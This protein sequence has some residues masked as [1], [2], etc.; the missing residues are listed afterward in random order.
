MNIVYNSDFFF[1]V[2]SMVPYLVWSFP[3]LAFTL[4]AFKVNQVLVAILPFIY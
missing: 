2:F 4:F 3:Y 1:V